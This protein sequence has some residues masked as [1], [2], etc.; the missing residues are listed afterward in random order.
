MKISA[1][2]IRRTALLTPFLFLFAHLAHAQSSLWLEAECAQAGSLWNRTSD[3]SASNGQYLVIQPGNN[4]T[5]N[6][7]SNTA[8]YITFPLSV[9]Q[10]GTY[11]L[12]AR[13]QGPTANDDSFWV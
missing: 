11:R 7:P 9:G 3:S 12:F 4:S 5:A 2:A 1:S 13:M 6:A 10:A 8:G